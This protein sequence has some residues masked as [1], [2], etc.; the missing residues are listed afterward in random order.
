MTESIIYDLVQRVREFNDSIAYDDND[1]D[2]SSQD[3]ET[4]LDY[5]ERMSFI[6]DGMAQDLIDTLDRD[7]VW[8]TVE[9]WFDEDVLMRTDRDAL[10]QE[11]LG[12]VLADLADEEE[13]DRLV[14]RA[15][16][17]DDYIK[18]HWLE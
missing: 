10:V 1:S 4:D 17:V 8:R 12:E 13:R 3:T 11:V 2:C 5:N 9:T 7:F 16:L 6:V 15:C 18:Y 14:L